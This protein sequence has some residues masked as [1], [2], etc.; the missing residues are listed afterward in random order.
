MQAVSCEG[1]GAVYFTFLA[2]SI[3][4]ACLSSSFRSGYMA[5]NVPASTQQA[6]TFAEI[7]SI[8]GVRECDRPVGIFPRNRSVPRPPPQRMR[9][10]RHDFLVAQALRPSVDSNDQQRQEK[11]S[12][13][14]TGAA[15]RPAGAENRHHV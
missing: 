8:A 6:V 12:P 5:R 13:A 2:N 14:A 4:F 7:T 11:S 10:A 3:F 9:Y 1:R 15:R